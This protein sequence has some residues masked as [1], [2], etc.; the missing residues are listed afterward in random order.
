[1]RRIERLTAEQERYLPEFRE[2]WLRRGLA[3]GACDRPKAEAAIRQLYRVGGRAEPEIILWLGSPWAGAVT[4]ALLASIGE[5]A[6][7]QLRGQLWDQLGDQLW[8]Q[9]WGQLWDQLWDQLGDQLWDQLWGQLWDQLGDQLGDQLRGQLR[10]QLG[11]QLRGQLWDQ[12]YRCG[13]G[14]H[15][16]SWVA[17]LRFG[18]HVGAHLDLVQALNA[19]DGLSDVG[20]WWPFEGL[21]ILTE[22]PGALHRDAQGRLHNLSGPALAYPDGYALYASHGVRLPARVI[23]APETLTPREILDERNAEVRRVMLE[24]LPGGVEAFVRG[25]NARQLHR[26]DW[27]TLWRV[28]QADDEPLVVVQVTNATA[29]PDGS[30]K[31]YWLRVHP[32]L[33]PLLDPVK[34]E[35]GAPQKPTALNAIAS[36]YGK[37]GEEYTP[38]FQS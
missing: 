28:D 31:D 9:L 38:V 10:D 11:D 26:D 37:R 24:R 13:Y 1:M 6:S 22:R 30:F 27:G 16:I 18:Q 36:T 33:R 3:T 21:C 32:E 12:L 35:F 14:Q 8:D 20:W 5:P 17:W 7:K 23:D 34:R 2:Q 4:A 15:D 19:F 29:E 25:V